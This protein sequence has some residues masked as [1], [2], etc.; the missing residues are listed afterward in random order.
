MADCTVLKVTH[1]A[2]RRNSLGI[3]TVTE[4]YMTSRIKL[5]PAAMPTEAKTDK[6]MS[7][8]DDESPVPMARS[9]GT[10][11]ASPSPNRTE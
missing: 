6:A 2:N 4:W 10:E 11:I 3:Q 7:L 9:N 8:R 5:A 1:T